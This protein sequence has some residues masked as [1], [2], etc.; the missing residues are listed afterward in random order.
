MATDIG[1]RVFQLIF[2]KAIVTDAVKVHF[3]MA[4]Y[5]RNENFAQLITTAEA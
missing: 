4:S 2:Q 5:S 1:R 3:S